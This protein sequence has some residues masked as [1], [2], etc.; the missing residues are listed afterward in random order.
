[1]KKEI[2]KKIDW[3]IDDY[4]FSNFGR[5]KK[6]GVIKT[7]NITKSGYYM[8]S[9]KTIFGEQR[10]YNLHQLIAVAFLN[11]K[12]IPQGLVVDHIN[13]NKI[14]NNVNNL[15][16]ITISE[17]TKKGKK[18]LFQKHKS[19]AKLIYEEKKCKWHVKIKHN[20]ITK[21]LFDFSSRD[22]AVIEVKKLLT[23]LRESVWD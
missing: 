17:N 2:W 15:Q 8:V 3:L 23:K 19:F 20:Q 14:D 10:S 13:E 9:V 6:N 7:F 11:H 21:Y 16:L 5:F 18:I 4:E 22:E 12:I 1:M